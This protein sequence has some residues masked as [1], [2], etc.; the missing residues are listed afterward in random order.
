MIYSIGHLT[1]EQSEAYWNDPKWREVERLSNVLFKLEKAIDIVLQ[2]QKS[3][4]CFIQ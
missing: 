3:H 1:D 2:I 4:N